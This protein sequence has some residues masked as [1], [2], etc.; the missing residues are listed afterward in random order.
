MD[1]LKGFYYQFMNLDQPTLKSQ[2]YLIWTF[3]HEI[4]FFTITLKFNAQWATD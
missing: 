4:I 3:E 1:V 2:E